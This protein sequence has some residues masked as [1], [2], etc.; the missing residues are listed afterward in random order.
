VADPIVRWTISVPQSVADALDITMLD[1]MSGAVRYG[2]R[3][4]LIVRLLREHLRRIQI[5]QQEVQTPH[6]P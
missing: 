5:A 2:A 4:G 3:S 6:D 1:P